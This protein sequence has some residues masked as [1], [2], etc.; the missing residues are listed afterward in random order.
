MKNGHP[1]DI[2]DQELF[3]SKIEKGVYNQYLDITISDK[4]LD[5]ERANSCYV[6]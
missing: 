3:M 6:N 1:D 2:S 4:K 5:D